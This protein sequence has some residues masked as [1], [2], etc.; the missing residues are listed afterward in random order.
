MQSPTKHYKLNNKQIHI[1][2]LIYK[3]RFINSSLLARYKAISRISANNSLKVLLD[4]DYIGSRYE[5]RYKI[6][7]KGPRY[8]LTPKGVRLV[9]A[10]LDDDLSELTIANLYRNKSV[11][12]TFVE[13]TIDVMSV[14]LAL[15]AMHPDIFHI[16]TRTELGDYD[17]FPKPKPDLYLNRIKTSAKSYNEYMLEIFTATPLFIIKYRI[18]EYLEHFDTDEWEAESETDYPVILIAC[19]TKSDEQQLQKYIASKLDN[20][21]IDNDELNIYTTSTQTLTSLDSDK[22][23]WTSVYDPKVLIS[24]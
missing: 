5:K 23:I 20:I 2:I 13:H 10:K 17:F 1:L 15:K 6:Q 9:K 12:E 18:K 21:G 19:P 8:Y 11:T 3:F 22:F 4:Q 24:I 16:F 14:V 7:G